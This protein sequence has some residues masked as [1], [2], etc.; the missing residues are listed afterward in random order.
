MP[1]LFRIL[2]IVAAGVVPFARSVVAD[3]WPYYQHD[4]WHTGDSSALVNP[5]ALS[6]A[7][8]APSSPTGY[9]TPVIVGNHIYAMQNQGGA[10]KSKRRSALSI[11]R[12][13]RSTGVILATSYFRRNQALAAGLLRLSA[14]L[15]PVLRSTCWMR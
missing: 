11:F 8:S 3:D 13:V 9:S 2:V 14:P 10:V 5:Q 15:F 4:V 12:L 1:E 6:L 7:W